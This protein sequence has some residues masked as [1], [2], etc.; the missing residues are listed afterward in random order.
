MAGDMSK[1]SNLR[2]SLSLEI[3]T[4]SNGFELHLGKYA[5]STSPEVDNYPQTEHGELEKYAQ[6]LCN[7]SQAQRCGERILN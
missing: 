4:Q 3:L 1:T 6:R 2:T 7:T 5:P